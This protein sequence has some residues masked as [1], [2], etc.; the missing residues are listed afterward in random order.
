MTNVYHGDEA[1]MNYSDARGP[2]NASGA[3]AG[4]AAGSGTR[5][6]LPLRG[7]AMVLISVAILLG[8]W[9]IFALTSSDETTATNT[10]NN[11]QNSAAEQAGGDNNGAPA[12]GGQGDEP[13]GAPADGEHRDGAHPGDAGRDGVEDPAGAQEHPHEGGHPEGAPGADRREAPAG[14]S[15]GAGAGAPQTFDVTVLNNSTVPGLAH[16]VTQ[17]LEREGQKTR[18][19]GN[20][21]GGEKVLRENTVFFPAGNAA[22]E[23]RARELADRV[24]GVAR[25][26]T[27]YLPGEAT[28][29]NGLTMVLIGEVAL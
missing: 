28:E 16:R 19:S 1:N 29:N 7:L 21:P 27:A 9:G 3:G 26:N 20:L 18:E 11:A 24:G 13:N 12:N 10:A 23:Q 17:S 22:A 4:G 5:S 15:G 2:E 14:R 25:E 6:G 8:L